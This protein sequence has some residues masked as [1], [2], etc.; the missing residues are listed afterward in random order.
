MTKI[1]AAL[2]SAFSGAL[3]PLFTFLCAIAS[4]SLFWS[5]TSTH[6]LASGFSSGVSLTTQP[7][8]WS[9][10]RTP[11]QIPRGGHLV[12]PALIGCPNWSASCGQGSEGMWYGPSSSLRPQWGEEACGW[13][14]NDSYFSTLHSVVD[15][16]LPRAC[17]PVLFLV[18]EQISPDFSV[19][20]TSPPSIL[21]SCLFPG[22]PQQASGQSL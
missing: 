5:L 7:G 21:H 10:C 13:K 6:P 18:S 22:P 12:G 15:F 1:E 9:S 19:I 17:A 4:F 3:W 16:L 2:V 11:I 20:A 8:P 14:G